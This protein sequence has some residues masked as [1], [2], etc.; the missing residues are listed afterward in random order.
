M[1]QFLKMLL[2]V[3]NNALQEHPGAIVRMDTFTLNEL[4]AIVKELQD[5]DYDKAQLR[6]LSEDYFREFDVDQSGSLDRNELE[7]MLKE[8]YMR[9][10]L[11][12][13]FDKD[14]VDQT[15]LD[16]DV[17]QDGKINLEE[18]IEMMEGFNTM[19]VKMYQAAIHQKKAKK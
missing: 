11:Q 9:R 8:Y 18:L 19:L 7:N 12:I 10:G 17:S 15:F 5:L 3:F 6:T 14:F 2:E 13:P 4:E 1:G 16:I